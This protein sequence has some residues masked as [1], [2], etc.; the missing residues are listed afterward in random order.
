M[1]RG[2]AN[3]LFGQY[4]HFCRDLFG[5]RKLFGFVSVL[6]IISLVLSLIYGINLWTDRNAKAT[7]YTFIDNLSTGANLDLAHSTASWNSSAGTVTSLAGDGLWDISG[8][9]FDTASSPDTPALSPS[10]NENEANCGANPANCTMFVRFNGGLYKS[11]DKGATW[12]DTL[13]GGGWSIDNATKI[14]SG[15]VVSLYA[16]SP[17]Y[18]NDSTIF[19]LVLDYTTLTYGNYKSTDGGSTWASFTAPV[20]LA[21]MPATSYSDTTA[22]C[23]TTPT[24]C[25]LFGS[26]GQAIYKSH[27][28]GVTWDNGNAAVA[29]TAAGD[30]T[31]LKVSPAYATD[32]TIIVGTEG[33][34]FF[35]SGD[36]TAAAA[37]CTLTEINTGVTLPTPGGEG[38]INDI[39]FSPAYNTD[40]TILAVSGGSAP[41]YTGQTFKTT[42]CNDPNVSACAWSKNIA[43]MA[44]DGLEISP[45]Y[46]S[47]A[48]SAE[49]EI[50]Y[51]NQHW[52]IQNW[53]S[54]QCVDDG[55]GLALGVECSQIA[56]L[57]TDGTMR[58]VT[59]GDM[60][61]NYTTDGTIIM[62]TL[63][64]GLQKAV[65]SGGVWTVSYLTGLSLGDLIDVQVSPNFASDNTIFA[66]S[67]E[68]DVA[69]E[70]ICNG[71]IYKSTDGGITWT[72]ITA[73][74]SY[75]SAYQL[76]PNYI[77]DST[78]YAGEWGINATACKFYK[79]TDG[80]ATW[81]QTASTISCAPVGTTYDRITVIAISPANSANLFL[82]TA[83]GKIYESIDSGAT[84]DAGTNVVNEVTDIKISPNFATDSEVLATTT[85]A[86]LVTI[87]GGTSWA[88]IP[89]GSWDH[90]LLAPQFD[91]TANCVANPE[92]CVA[93][94][95]SNTTVSLYMTVDRFEGGASDITPTGMTEIL[96]T[97]AISPDYNYSGSDKRIW[98]GFNDTPQ[99]YVS[100]NSGTAKNWNLMPSA[101][102]SSYA[103]QKRGVNLGDINGDGLEDL[104]NATSIFLNATAGI[105]NTADYTLN[106]I[107]AGGD[108]NGDGYADVLD[109]NGANL[110]V[111][112]GGSTFNTVV[113]YTLD[114]VDVTAETISDN[115][116]TI[117][118]ING[119]GFKD[120]IVG[121]YTYNNGEGANQGGV[122]IYFGGKLFND[123]YDYAL[124]GAA[125]GDL[126][127]AAVSAGDVNGDGFDDLAISAPS[128]SANTG[129]VYIYY[130]GKSFDTTADVTL[131]G[132][133]GDV[134]GIDLSLAGDV[135]GDGYNDIVVGASRAAGDGDGRV[136][137]FNGS[138]SLA[139]T[140]TTVSANS[141]INDSADDSGS[142]FGEL[143]E[144]A[145]VDKDGYDDVVVAAPDYRASAGETFHRGKFYAYYGA[146]TFN[147]TADYTYDPGEPASDYGPDAS[148]CLI[149]MDNNGYLDLRG[150]SHN[151]SD[152]IFTDDTSIDLIWK[153]RS[154]LADVN[155][156]SLVVSPNYDVD[157]KIFLSGY[158]ELEQSFSYKYN[159]ST[160]LSKIVD[161][162]V[163]NINVATL[164]ATATTPTNTSVTYY[165]SNNG[166]R[167]WEA[168]TSGVAHTFTTTGSDLRWKAIL[169]T[170]DVAYS[171]SISDI[172][173]TYGNTNPGTPSLTAPADGATGV[174]LNP[175]FEFSTT[176]TDS[177]TL[178]YIL[179]IAAD[180][181]FNKDV[182]TFYQKEDN[183]WYVKDD[184]LGWS[185]VNFYNSGDT[186]SFTLPAKYT[187]TPKT[188]YYW[189]VAGVDENGGTA[190]SATFSFTAIRGSITDTFDTTVWRDSAT[191]TTEWSAVG[192]V[193]RAPATNTFAV[194]SAA[195][196]PAAAAN[197]TSFIL[198]VDI[199][200][201]GDQD[202]VAGNYGNPMYLYKN[203][204][205]GTFTESTPFPDGGTSRNTNTLLAVDL[206]EDGD[207]D[208]IQGNNGQNYYYLNN[209][210]GTFGA[211]SEYS[212]FGA[213]NTQSLDAADVNKDGDVDILEGTAAQDK[214]WLNDGDG[215]F[216][217]SDTFNA[218]DTRTIKAVDVDVDGDMDVI[219]C[220]NGVGAKIYTND[221]TGAFTLA[222]TLAYAAGSGNDSLVVNDF[223][224]DGDEDIIAS[225][226]A[227]LFLYQNNGQG[228]F[229]AN[230][231]FSFNYA[232]MIDV[233]ADLD[234]DM[235]LAVIASGVGINGLLRNKGSGTFT[236]ETGY[237]ASGSAN[238]D[239]AD[240]LA[241]ADIDKDGDEDI[242]HYFSCIGGTC[243]DADDQNYIYENN[244]HN[245]DAD[246]GWAQL[247]GGANFPAQTSKIM[248]LGD[249]NYDG[250]ED[251]A[252]LSGAD[253]ATSSKI[254]LGDGGGGF[255][256]T[257]PFTNVSCANNDIDGAADFNGDGYLDILVGADNGWDCV[258]FNDGAGNFSTITQIVSIGNERQL[259][260]A[261]VEGDGDQDII[262]FENG[263]NFIFRN[264]GDGSTFIQEDL[265]LAWENTLQGYTDDIDNDGD[266]DILVGDRVSQQNF[267][268]R[269][270][271][272]G[273]FIRESQFGEGSTD[274][275]VSADLNGDSWKDVV[276]SNSDINSAIYWNNGQG[277]FTKQSL[278]TTGIFRGDDLDNDGDVDL[279]LVGG[280]A[281]TYIYRNDGRGDFTVELLS[282][283]PSSAVFAHDIN[284]DS[285][286][287]LLVA[288]SSG[289]SF[290]F[291]PQLTQTA[292][293]Y[294]AQSV[295]MANPGR[296]ILR[297]T[298]TAEHYLP[299]AS[300]IAYYLSN[301]GGTTWV[302]VTNG[303]EYVFAT[304]G[305][306]LRWKA[307]L[308]PDTDTPII[309]NVTLNYAE[310]IAAGFM[311]NATN[312]R[313]FGGFDASSYGGRE[314]HAI[315]WVVDF[316][317]DFLNESDRDN[318]EFV[319]FVTSD[320]M[321]DVVS[322]GYTTPWS[323]YLTAVYNTDQ[324]LKS[325]IP[326][327]ESTVYAYFTQ[328]YFGFYEESSKEGLKYN[329]K[330]DGR[331]VC[332]KNKITNAY[333]GDCAVCPAVWTLAEPPS[334]PTL[335]A[336]LTTSLWASVDN[337]SFPVGT[338]WEQAG[339]TFEIYEGD[340]I[341]EDGTP[342]ASEFAA[343]QNSFTFGNLKPD[344]SYTIRA[345]GRN[346][347]GVDTPWSEA[348]TAKTLPPSF[349]LI[350]TAVIKEPGQ[351]EVK[352]SAV[353]SSSLNIGTKIQPL[354]NLKY[355]RNFSA[356]M[357]FF[358]LISLVILSYHLV[359]W[360]RAARS[361]VR[362]RFERKAYSTLAM[363]V[364]LGIVKVAMMATMAGLNDAS[365]K[366]ENYAGNGVAVQ[367]EDSIVYQIDYIN[368]TKDDLKNVVI[369]D[370]IDSVIF[371]DGYLKKNSESV[372]RL[373][374]FLKCA[375]EEE[376]SS[377]EIIFNLGEVK[378]GQSG[379]LTL[380]FKVSPDEVKQSVPHTI[381]NVAK[382]EY[383]QNGENK[384]ATSNTL[385]NPVSAGAIDIFTFFDGNNNG[386]YDKGEKGVQGI[387]TLV[388]YDLNGDG[389][390]SGPQETEV[391]VY[392]VS[393]VAG[394]HS[395]V[396]GRRAGKH[397]V[398]IGKIEKGKYSL[399]LPSGYTLT[400]SEMVT[401]DLERG[402][403]GSAYFGLYKKAEQKPP[404]ITYPG[405]NSEITD[406]APTIRGNAYVSNGA[407]DIYLDGEYLDSTKANSEG[408]FS[409]TLT[410]ELLFG[411]HTLRVKVGEVY[412]S[413]F[414][415]KVTEKTAEEIKEEQEEEIGEKIR[416]T[417]IRV[418]IGEINIKE[419]AARLEGVKL[420]EVR[421]GKVSAESKLM[422]AGITVIMHNAEIGK[423]YEL[424]VESEI[425]KYEFTPQN[426]EWAENIKI[427][428]PPGAHKS[429][430][431]VYDEIAKEYKIISNVEEFTVSLPAC[432]D[433]AD[434]D[435]DGQTDYPADAGCLSID[436]NNEEDIVES[437]VADF[438]NS[439]VGTVEVIVNTVGELA[440]DPQVEKAAQNYVAPTLVAVVAVNASTAISFVYLIP[441]L[442]FIFTEPFRLLSRRKRKGWGTVYNSISKEPIDLAIVRLINVQNGTL[443][444]T[445]ITDKQGRYNL[446][447]K[448]A[449]TYRIEVKK[450]EF[451]YPTSLLGEKKEDMAFLDLYHGE[452][453]KVEAS[454]AVITANIPLDPVKEDKPNRKILALAV[455]RR[456]Q[457][458]ISLSGL[459]LSIVT[460]A[461]VP[462][463]LMGIL[464]ALHFMLYFLFRRLAYPSKPKGW[465]IVYDKGTK[466]PLGKAVVR[467]FDIQFNKLLAA[468]VTDSAGRYGFLVGPNVYYLTSEREDYKSYKS[469]PIDLAKEKAG[470]ITLDMPLE[471][472]TEGMG[473]SAPPAP[474]VPLSRPAASPE[475]KKE[476]PPAPAEIKDAQQEP[477][478]DSGEKGKDIMDDIDTGFY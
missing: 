27:D 121:I 256:A 31:V 51:F 377:C 62:S 247:Y 45:A 173:I 303:V 9:G 356:V 339:V 136:Y 28:K 345:R 195:L 166:G 311:V 202:I 133:A 111:L 81:A 79:S 204:G 218:G 371:D 249:V 423:T 38:Y 201:D 185:Q 115:G 69:G 384:S 30:I 200:T 219:V 312:C 470:A 365:I 437:P 285:M 131:T 340:R 360:N 37:T 171:A 347:G 471:K 151:S 190:Y 310:D 108:I 63:G 352:G 316:P 14:V 313:G 257:A 458:G 248:P 13:A 466:K 91:G 270:N 143:V 129:R 4:L 85:G 405:D 261:D 215:T 328:E 451:K 209:G 16:L 52:E 106:N 415:F 361:M 139:S 420:S 56:D 225:N 102:G 54:W 433:G 289:D 1:K 65:N 467:I 152:T 273:T 170:T 304:S 167:T 21:L 123:V 398:K 475:I 105:D 439:L 298:L 241:A 158:G 386:Q 278:G 70:N 44:Q 287:E 114:D 445:Q 271:G 153:S 274:N 32:G 107:Y 438:L 226:G 163:E 138:A 424:V 222:S 206:D 174:S 233:D 101:F 6:A 183:I 150:V 295:A 403:K 26:T 344:T 281:G 61:P 100:S 92:K 300:T 146:P 66:C 46:N 414:E 434:N 198:S 454:G 5:L 324:Y 343:G 288:Y 425:Y 205:S 64:Q 154:S 335:Q 144:A 236:E 134:F 137:V 272:S 412:S 96:R 393:S 117:A 99:I 334:K 208:I 212:G 43:A 397:F 95:W 457:N 429:Y 78:I 49:D 98:A 346:G 176:D 460:F 354:E 379:Y 186:A 411:A 169:A 407:V 213:S 187:L 282:A 301:D 229:T 410:D 441:Y 418:T 286:K 430:V 406:T 383:T 258:Y 293:T 118:D 387:R 87:D 48:Y 254:Y 22:D 464:V 279:Y 73:A 74:T 463:L 252:V 41:T 314:G 253:A 160:I 455:G 67:Q 380:P 388:Y 391:N 192:E 179:E 88:V 109:K 234:G 299:G 326:A 275:I 327:K 358:I 148:I 103:E 302:A 86:R 269:N 349:T 113:D 210:S 373:E 368:Q 3:K 238:V 116:V 264:N 223:D 230:A 308:T 17:D 408:F 290:I 119:D 2:K 188:T 394:G 472:S 357:S 402:G 297:A 94:V 245:N 395:T 177:D 178:H 342:L 156:K 449:G 353:L 72:R 164:T 242:I 203:N 162:T 367:P 161:S 323:G 462:K 232:K 318:L 330:L 294:I 446:I 329:T 453:I 442:Q 419:I 435:G 184:S 172:S 243:A 196:S 90:L 322:S 369:K 33:S 10:Y 220:D 364:V 82:G 427:S 165:L 376:T 175:T 378:A 474:E 266:V 199:D 157:K 417:I 235:D 84:F 404:V 19:V 421:Q 197:D 477:K 122:V 77:T 375:G 317:I 126:F 59:D 348:L 68:G 71:F 97:I 124:S 359:L 251:L 401:V 262:I 259:W 436:D 34:G 267:L 450:V 221:G 362:I 237:F 459:G 29:S 385:L 337:Y 80:G 448:E 20:A 473:I 476:I 191:T 422:D 217:S 180:S 268:Y 399:V 140:L 147:T 181:S 60:S 239:K 193:I 291:T 244:L 428:L 58:K 396:D 39:E 128:Y 392:S 431:R 363:A 141:T 142:D 374:D 321:V 389:A 93:W 265:G 305:S 240:N 372:G 280:A 370:K 76:S 15:K 57:T 125:A 132:D 214:L 432:F 24:G 8:S 331:K 168:A 307:V 283:A 447:I 127:G 224:N 320:K 284:R 382:A 315:I 461:I 440:D 263:Q 23:V 42:T 468:Q 456:V 366:V 228:T 55:G 12:T 341:P 465:G 443:V 325:W 35:G 469:S 400:T 478:V 309:Y 336:A 250:Y 216:T 155:Y 426:E 227:S 189:R 145:D 332:V 296:N 135:N 130:G 260:P 306:D 276:V 350:K 40:N 413:L 25:T 246:G 194:G 7:G 231:A 47:A 277:S 333:S 149:D 390:L 110:E 182:L 207:K 452:N 211:A 255:T 75:I 120:I 338:D 112:L 104:A 416:D 381:S 292:G 18:D 351:G 409:Y 36:C 50:Y 11:E 444:Q 83:G 159:N 355:L 319:P 89:G 53:G